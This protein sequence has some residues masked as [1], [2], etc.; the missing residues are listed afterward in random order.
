MKKIYIIHGWAYNLDKWNDFCKHLKQAGYEPVQLRVPGLTEPSDQTFTIDDYVGWLD[1]QLKHEKGERVVMAHSNGGRIALHY[2][3]QHPGAISKLILVDSAGNDI[4]G[5]VGWKR[6]VITPLAKVAK[7]FI[8][9]AGYRKA[10]YKFIKA[11]DYH[12]APQNMKATM[13][14]MLESDRGFDEQIRDIHVPCLIV[15]GERDQL[16]PLRDGKKL[17][18]LL[19]AK[20]HVIKEAR[21]APFAT[22]PREVLALV[23][24]F[25]Q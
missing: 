13:Q 19:R 11:T 2:L 9:S 10:V 22:H 18:E 3:A 17:A 24:E 5:R 6:R 21:H 1:E 15:W 23:K 12:N 4:A 25:L 7:R 8:R 14:N 16:T 20:L